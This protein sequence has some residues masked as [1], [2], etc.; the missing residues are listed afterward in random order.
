MKKFWYH[1]L[2]WP[3][4]IGCGVAL[5]GLALHLML[6]LMTRD[7]GIP[8]WFVII[9]AMYVFGYLIGY[10]FQDNDAQLRFFYEQQN[11]EEIRTE[12]DK[13]IKNTRKRLSPE[14]FAKVQSIRASIE[15]VLPNLINTTSA[16]H[17]LF[18]V[19]QTV[20][21]YLPSTLENYLKLPTPYARM[22][23]LRDGKTAQQLLDEQLT[24]IDDTMHKVV[25]NVFEQDVNELRIN[26]RFLR[27][28]LGGGNVELFTD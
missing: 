16:N 28:R 2:S 7:G 6:E 3:N 9:P 27:D 26:Q 12:L 21:D 5:L 23:K 8:F 18:T 22:H 24:V 25:Q 4:I 14:L 10:L 15:A 1:V 19:K 11:I 20:F 17:D 13:L